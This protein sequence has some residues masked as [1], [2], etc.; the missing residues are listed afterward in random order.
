M[1]P[2]E[3]KLPEIKALVQITVYYSAVQYDTSVS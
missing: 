2:V 3:H 1:M